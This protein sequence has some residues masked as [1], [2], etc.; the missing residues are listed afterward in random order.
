MVYVLGINEVLHDTAAALLD[1]HRVIAL[2]EEER[3]TRVKQKP[4]FLL[5]GDGPTMSIDWCLKAHGLK[6]SDIDAVGVSFD[7]S[8]R[9]VLK[10]LFDTVWQS[11]LKTPL[12]LTLKNRFTERD[13]GME[14]LNAAIPSYLL[15]RR[16]FL[17]ELRRRFKRVSRA[18]WAFRIR[19]ILVL[20]S[21]Q[22]CGDL[23]G[24]LFKNI[25]YRRDHYSAAANRAKF[26]DCG[27]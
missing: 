26:I 6:D 11:V 7:V 1:E 18:V 12:G 4:G 21:P 8:F 14:L 10:M 3:L 13:V 5:G 9:Q 19:S 24:F 27:E 20:Q 22:H 25:T 15:G 16:R 23:R 17:K 2:M